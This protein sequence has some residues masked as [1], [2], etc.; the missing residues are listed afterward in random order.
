M[1]MTC[2]RFLL[3]IEQFELFGVDQLHEC[4][5]LGFV[6]FFVRGQTWQRSSAQTIE[7]RLIASAVDRGGQRRAPLGRRAVLAPRIVER[8]RWL[9]GVCGGHRGRCWRGGARRPASQRLAGGVG[10]RRHLVEYSCLRTRATLCQMEI[11]L[12]I[13][14]AMREDFRQD[15]L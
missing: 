9:L 3:S 10:E 14:P 2:M 5:V 4:L 1:T 8:R 7:Y 15:I 6:P 13:E 12:L 11:M